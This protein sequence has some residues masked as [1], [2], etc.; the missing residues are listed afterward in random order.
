LFDTYLKDKEIKKI[1]YVSGKLISF[2]V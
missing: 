2:V 1:I